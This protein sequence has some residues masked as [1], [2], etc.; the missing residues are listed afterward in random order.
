M[1]WTS[2][3]SV[4]DSRGG[5]F[6]AQGRSR[7]SWRASL[8]ASFWTSES[9]LFGQRHHCAAPTPAFRERSLKWEGNP[10]GMYVSPVDLCLSKLPGQITPSS[11]DWS[12]THDDLVTPRPR[13]QRPSRTIFNIS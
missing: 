8:V 4:H 7:R 11:S 13:L 1:G 9:V 10:R 2:T 3:A 12:G 5:S 6:A